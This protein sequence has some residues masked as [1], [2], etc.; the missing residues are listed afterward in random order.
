MSRWIPGHPRGKGLSDIT[1]DSSELASL[2]TA[3]DRRQFFRIEDSI[4]LRYQQVPVEALNGRLQR[5]E[6]EFESNFTVVSAL[7]AITQRMAGVLHR[8]D[9]MRPDIASYLKSL[10]EK[11]EVLGR[12]FLLQD[13]DIA[14]HPAHAV[15]LSATGMAFHAEEPVELGELLEL[16]ILLLPS[17][18]GILTYG[19][20]VGCDEISA[21]DESLPYAV[22]VSFSH[23]RENDRDVLIRH[24][25]KRQSAMLR[26]ERERREAE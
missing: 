4:H 10:D 14:D 1:S 21:E 5:L 16:R 15:N 26:K 24:V 11:I 3:D 9:S 2:N 13:S 7:A 22:R 17:F 12:A 20:V 19:E 8:I 18:T 6:Q 23:L 25:V